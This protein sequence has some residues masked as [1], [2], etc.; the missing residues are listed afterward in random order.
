MPMR[1]Q[2]GKL[3]F[4]ASVAG[5]ILIAFLLDAGIMWL[6]DSI[7]AGTASWIPTV[8]TV[9]QTILLY[10]SAATLFAFVIV[11]VMAF[12]LGKKYGQEAE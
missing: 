12:W 10:S 5:L 6:S 11:P 4:P 9:G 8:G 7:M 1:N 3:R 2:T